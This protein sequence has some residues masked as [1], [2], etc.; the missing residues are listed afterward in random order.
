[1]FRRLEE[2]KKT[3]TALS[4][5]K[6]CNS[7]YEHNEKRLFSVPGNAKARANGQLTTSDEEKT[8]QAP[9]RRKEPIRVR[10]TVRRM[11][12]AGGKTPS[13]AANK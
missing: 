3:F 2:L 8:L 1:M 7:A 12:I 4:G 10:S 13:I 11:A 6:S 5:E 9:R